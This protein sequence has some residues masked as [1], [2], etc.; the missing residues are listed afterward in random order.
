MHN[1][2]GPDNFHINYIHL[3]TF[4]NKRQLLPI[5]ES[6]LWWWSRST[7]MMM[8]AT[9]RATMFSHLPASE[10]KPNFPKVWTSQNSLGSQLDTR[11]RKCESLAM[12][13]GHVKVIRGVAD[14]WS[15]ASEG[16][17]PQIPRILLSPPRIA[18]PTMTPWRFPSVDADDDTFFS[19]F[20][21]ADTKK[22]SSFFV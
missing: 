5:P 22:N 10:G 1:I 8:M 13:P 17:V 9:L 21:R 3:C 15:S 4:I 16:R 6:C 14:S 19:T 18:V 7:M 20:H 11:K 2:T 12:P